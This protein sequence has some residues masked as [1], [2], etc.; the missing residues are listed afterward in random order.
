VRISYSLD[1]Y[2][3]YEK[4]T[5]ENSHMDIIQRDHY[6]DEGCNCKAC[7]LKRLETISKIVRGIEVTERIVHI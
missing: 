4:I 1:E 5:I 7:C 6:F 2:K 3:L